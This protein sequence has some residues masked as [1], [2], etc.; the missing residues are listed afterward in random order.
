MTVSLLRTLLLYASLVCALRL[1]GKRQIGQLEPTELVV[2]ILVSE[3]AAIPMQD[4]GIPLSAGIVPIVTLICSEIILSFFSLKSNSLRKAFS[5]KPCIIIKNGKL[6]RKKLQDMRITVNE[7]LQELRLNNI[8]SIAD[9]RYGIIET[10]GQLSYVLNNPAKPLNANMMSVMPNTT[11]V[12]LLIISD[13]KLLE[14]NV[15]ALNK[16]NDWILKQVKKNHI[17]SIENVF[18]MTLDDS[19]NMF[20][21]SKEN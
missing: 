11:G 1:M 12:P 9:V 18:I 13:G 7:V 8:D 4:P 16:T 2:T 19:E 10:N 17:S 20:I 6:D 15:L 5:G 21:Q 14:E 3:L